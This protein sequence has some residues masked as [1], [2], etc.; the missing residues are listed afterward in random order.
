MMRAER[1]E[2][3]ARVPK[4]VPAKCFLRPSGA[5]LK[6]FPY[7]EFVRRI[8]LMAGCVSLSRPTHSWNAEIFNKHKYFFK[9]NFIYIILLTFPNIFGIYN[10]L[11]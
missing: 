9:N 5:P 2:S 10:H 8:G 7:R 1:Q 6:F 4:N 3:E 11:E